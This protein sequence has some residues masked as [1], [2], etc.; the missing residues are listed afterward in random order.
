M[1]AL[2]RL[3]PTRVVLMGGT[4]ALSA[5]VAD[6]V[7]SVVSGVDLLRLSGT[8]RVDTAARAALDGASGAGAV[9]W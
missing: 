3:R 2:Q 8:D 5:G 9:Q 4:A 7:R 6:E 1:A